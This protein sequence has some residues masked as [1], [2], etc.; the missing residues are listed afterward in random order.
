MAGF[1]RLQKEV[2]GVG[3]CADCGACA[4]VC[5]SK[6]VV[7]NLDTEEP[8]LTKECPPRCTLCYQI[9][10]G[11]DIPMLE[12]DRATF[13]RARELGRDEELL[14]ICQEFLKAYAV[15]DEVRIAGASG[16][17]APALMIYALENDIIDGAI[18]AGMDEERPWRMVPKIATNREEVIASAQTKY[19]LIPTG[20]ILG[21]AVD[22]GFRRLGIVGVP[23]LIHAIRKMQLHGKPKRI[24]SSIQFVLGL[25]EGGNAS[26]RGTEHTLE[27][28]VGVPTGQVA[29][30]WYRAGEFPGK[31]T[32]VTKDGKTIAVSTFDYIW[33]CIKYKR[34]RCLMCFDY[35]SE[36][37][38][39]SLGDYFYQQ[40]MKRGMPGITAIMVRTDIGK[41]LVEGAQ[42]ANYIATEPCEKENFFMGQFEAKKHA[43]SYHIFTRR[44]H[45]WPTPNNPLPLHLAPMPRG[46]SWMNRNAL[47]SKE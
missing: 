10:P 5:P 27:E 23:C 41:R 17:V 36:L 24:L 31:F 7:M 8:E 12:L 16:G 44:K 11:K 38:D 34:D 3:L 28:V 42:R 30:L 37:A 35:T 25:V 32:V 26:Y 14:G 21:E 47:L 22:K 2:I 18:V 4:G 19:T 13:G 6:C 9:C 1:T 45:G 20:S 43:G 33:H 29:K 46:L 40:E 15:D 39:I